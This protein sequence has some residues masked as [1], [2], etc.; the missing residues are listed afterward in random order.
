MLATFLSTF[1]P[2]ADTTPLSDADLAPYVG[3]VPPEVEQLWKQHGV[4]TYGEGLFQVVD[5]ARYEQAIYPWI[6]RD[7]NKRYVPLILTAFGSLYYLRQLNNPVTPEYAHDITL[8]DPHTGHAKHVTFDVAR[9]FE[10]HLPSPEAQ[11][12]E[13]RISAW[14]AARAAGI[15]APAKDQML[16]FTP[17]LVMGGDGD[18][19]SCDPGDAL[20]HWDILRQMGGR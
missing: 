9:F 13:L 14:N 6:F 11:E 10:H 15:P 17:A 12:N 4:G 3:I 8:L 5:P 7:E 18:P 20:V 1:P 2:A 19:T 16:C